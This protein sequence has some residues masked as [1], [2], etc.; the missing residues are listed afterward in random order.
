MLRALPGSFLAELLFELI[1]DCR[2]NKHAWLFGALRIISKGLSFPRR[3]CLLAR[4]E[5]MLDRLRVE[6]SAILL[7]IFTDTLT[8]S[9]YRE[10][11]EKLAACPNGSYR[12]LRILKSWAAQDRDLLPR[13]S[14]SSLHYSVQNFRNLVLLMLGKLPVERTGAF[15]NIGLP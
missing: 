13:F 9:I 14:M 2:V 3:D 11:R 4:V 8:Q 6:P 7:R 12:K 5:S 1:N 10:A 15:T